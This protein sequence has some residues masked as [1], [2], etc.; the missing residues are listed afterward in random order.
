MILLRAAQVLAGASLLFS[1]TGAAYALHLHLF[2]AAHGEHAHH[3]NDHCP[4][5]QAMVL[6]SK[7]VVTDGPAPPVP[8]DGTE[9]E[10]P[11]C[12]RAPAQTRIRLP[13]APRAP[14]PAS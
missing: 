6:G 7:A 10:G 12:H 11:A 3:D 13:S 4:V 14:P 9:W 2:H 1:T 5:F 8:G